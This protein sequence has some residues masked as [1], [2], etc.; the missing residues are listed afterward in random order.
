MRAAAI[1]RRL[2]QLHAIATPATVA[3][4]CGRGPHATVRAAIAVRLASG[5][6]AQ[7]KRKLKAGAKPAAAAA[8]AVR[9]TGSRVLEPEKLGTGV[10]MCH[11]VDEEG[12][13]KCG[14]WWS[15]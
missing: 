10:G 15:F 5:S 7:P 13:G 1:A 4:A 6:A 14:S 12:G 9:D 11:G 3:Q 2:Y 8:A